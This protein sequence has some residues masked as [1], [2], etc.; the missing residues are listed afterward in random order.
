[1]D[2]LNASIDK[3]EIDQAHQTGKNIKMM[4]VSG[5]NLFYSSLTAGVP[6]IGCTSYERTQG[7]T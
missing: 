3:L 2:H 1:M 4:M 5:S 6:E 7:S